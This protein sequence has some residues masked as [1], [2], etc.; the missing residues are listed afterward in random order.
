[1]GIV[2]SPQDEGG[3][4]G[5]RIISWHVAPGHKGWIIQHVVYHAHVTRS[6]QPLAEK[7]KNVDDSY[8]EGWEVT[9]DG[10]VWGGR[11]ES[12]INDVSSE[13]RGNYD[14]FVNGQGP[15]TEGDATF[16]GYAKFIENFPMTWGTIGALS[17]LPSSRTPP[18][19]WTDKG[20]LVHTLEIHWNNVDLPNTASVKGRE[21]Y[22]E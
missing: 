4:A 19:G 1:M 16:T 17:E 10:H 20:T 8:Y 7:K 21:F 5:S 11:K 12:G 9:S 14:E 2:N 15:G 22:Q 6:T 18:E 3:G 13:Q